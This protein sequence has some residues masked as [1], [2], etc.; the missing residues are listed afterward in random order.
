MTRDV[1]RLEASES[2][3]QLQPLANEEVL[4]RLDRMIPELSEPVSDE[5]LNLVGRSDSIENR[6]V[7]RRL[8]GRESPASASSEERLN[9]DTLRRWRLL[10]HIFSIYYLLK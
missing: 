1:R 2:V 3:P 8:G 7:S 6:S 5:T 4:N 9:L 10:K